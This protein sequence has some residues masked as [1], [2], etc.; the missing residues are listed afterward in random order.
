MTLLLI[1]F[2]ASS[3]RVTPVICGQP[4]DATLGRWTQERLE[5]CRATQIAAGHAPRLWLDGR[6]VPYE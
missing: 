6:V 4:I 1:A 3:W 2:V 5:R